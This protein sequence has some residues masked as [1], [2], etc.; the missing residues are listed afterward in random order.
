MLGLLASNPNILTALNNAQNVTFLAPNNDA[1]N[2][3]IN[4]SVNTYGGSVKDPSWVAN[5]LNYHVIKG[6][7]QSSAFTDKPAFPHTLLNNQSY[8]NVTDGQVVQVQKKDGKVVAYSG[9]KY[10]STVKTA[11]SSFSSSPLKLYSG[12]D[13]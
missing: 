3:V 7:Y 8:T 4:G 5:L 1:L 2:G 12:E 6:A 13:S 11:V 10:Y 9:L